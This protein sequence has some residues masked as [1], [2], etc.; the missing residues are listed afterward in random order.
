V[1]AIGTSLSGG[2]LLIDPPHYPRYIDPTPALALLVALGT[3]QIALMAGDLGDLLAGGAR[4]LKKLLHAGIAV[5]VRVQGW[6]QHRPLLPVALAFVLMLANGRSFIFD[7]LPVTESHRLLYGE[8][9]IQLNQIANILKSFHGQY[10]VR[11]FSSLDLDMNGTD[12]LRYLTPEN[13]GIEILSE[14]PGIWRQELPP[15]SYAFVIAPGRYA[16]VGEELVRRFPYGQMREYTNTRTS[17]PLIYVYFTHVPDL[18]AGT[19]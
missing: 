19:E 16:E 13:S 4:R 9:T 7:Y 12:L 11:R 10:E 1:W 3:T 6:V 15:G 17:R 8:N 2:A 18:P 14:D 5:P